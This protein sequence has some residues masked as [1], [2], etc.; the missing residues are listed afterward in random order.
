[1]DRSAHFLHDGPMARKNYDD[2]VDTFIHCLYTVCVYVRGKT[3]VDAST[4]VSEIKCV[5]RAQE[6]GHLHLQKHLFSIYNRHILLLLVRRKQ[7]LNRISH[8]V[9]KKSDHFRSLLSHVYDETE[10]QT[11]IKMFSTLSNAGCFR[12]HHY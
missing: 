12:S 10:R 4:I 9:G 5:L 8:R 6:V 3:R 1:M 11:H 2:Y 7:P